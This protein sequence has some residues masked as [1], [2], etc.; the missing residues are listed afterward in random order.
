MH[1]GTTPSYLS[2]TSVF[3]QIL[4]LAEGWAAISFKSSH[5]EAQLG[6]LWE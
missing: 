2:R 3:S 1:L 5:S 6:P 4:L